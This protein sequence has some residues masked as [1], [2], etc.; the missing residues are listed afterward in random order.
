VIEE[1]VCTADSF[2][3]RS[4]WML[5][6]PLL[7]CFSIV[8]VGSDRIHFFGILRIDLIDLRCKNSR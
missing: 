8:S 4:V 1:D 3:T 2:N 5:L 6:G 7:L